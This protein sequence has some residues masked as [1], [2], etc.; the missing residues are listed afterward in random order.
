[1]VINRNLIYFDGT[2][3]NT[4]R[5]ANLTEGVWLSTVGLGTISYMTSDAGV[6]Y[7][8]PVQYSFTLTGLIAG[9]EVRI[10]NS[11]TN[12]EI[13]GVESSSTTFSYTYVYTSDIPIF[14]VVFSL[15]YKDIRLTGLTLSNGNQSIPIQQQ[16]DRNYLNP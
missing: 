10:F 3:Y 13:D 1:L 4:E 2:G 7:I 5:N 11:D 14:V 6:Q 16:F 9:T 8:P 15:N 12:E